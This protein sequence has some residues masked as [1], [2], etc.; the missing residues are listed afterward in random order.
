M[1][2]LSRFSSRKGKDRSTKR[3]PSDPSSSSSATQTRQD[4]LPLTLPTSSLL[5]DAS[6]ASPLLLSPTSHAGPRSHTA[7]DH[8]DDDLRSLR[9]VDT[10]PWVHIDASTAADSPVRP[11]QGA[12]PTP[13]REHRERVDP[14]REKRERVRL[15]RARLGPAEVTLLLDECGG[16]IRSRGEPL[17]SLLLSQR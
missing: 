4:L 12:P 6:R 8:D 1:S 2:F 17:P 13:Q 10:T 7:L 14:A 11:R 9:S 16:V 15:E 3:S 5:A